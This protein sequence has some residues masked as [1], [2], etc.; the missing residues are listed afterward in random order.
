MKDR[1]HLAE[2][3]LQICHG[4]LTNVQDLFEFSDIRRQTIFKK[5]FLPS[6]KFFWAIPCTSLSR[7]QSCR[8]DGQID[9]ER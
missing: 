4:K 5:T 3:S 8:M 1:G 2:D 9:D 7:N 6:F